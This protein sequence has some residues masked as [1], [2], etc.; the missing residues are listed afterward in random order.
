MYAGSIQA[1]HTIPSFNTV[2][3]VYRVSLA[4]EQVTPLKELYSVVAQG[5]RQ[6][7]LSPTTGRSNLDYQL[8][9]WLALLDHSAKCTRFRLRPS[10]SHECSRVT[11]SSSF[12]F[13]HVALSTV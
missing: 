3:I 13:G 10:R 9:L 11:L 5:R 12:V 4:Q 8:S 6:V 2:Q 1:S 7:G